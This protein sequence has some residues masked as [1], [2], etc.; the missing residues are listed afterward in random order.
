LPSDEPNSTSTSV[1]PGAHVVKDRPDVRDLPYRPTLGVLRG[2]QPVPIA[3]SS[4]ADF[5]RTQGNGSCTAHALAAVIDILRYDPELKGRGKIGRASPVSAAMLYKYGREIDSIDF[6]A[7]SSEGEGLW[8]LRSAIKAFYHNGVCEN[9]VW[10]AT[11]NHDPN[12]P[13]EIR[14]YRHARQTP[15]GSYYRVDPILND[16]HAAL[17]EV[18][19]IYAAAE[20]HGGWLQDNVNQNG[21]KII[22]DDSTALQ[23]TGKHAFAIVG[24]TEKGFLVLNSWGPEWGGYREGRSK[25]IK[26]VALWPYYDWAERILDGWVLRLGVKAPEAFKYSF[27]RQG[28]GDFLSGQIKEGSTPRFE[29][30]GHYA[31]LDDGD[32]V[33]GGTLPTSIE[34]VQDTCT[35]IS[36]KLARKPSAKAKADETYR[37]LLVWL[38]GGSEKM[39][40]IVAHIAATKQLWKQRGVYPFTL[41]WCSDLLD[42]ASAVLS[43]FAEGA[44]TNVGR[45]GLAFDTRLERDARGIGRAVWRDVINSAKKAAERDRSGDNK[46]AGAAQQVMEQFVQIDKDIEIHL[47][48][49]GA[50]AILA[51]ELIANNPDFAPRISSFT[52]IMPGFSIAQFQDFL[53]RSRAT[54][55]TRIIVPSSATQ[56]RLRYGEYN[57]SLL[58]LVQMTF[59]ETPPARLRD[60][61]PELQRAENAKLDAKDR[62]VGA[63]GAIEIQNKIAGVQ[64][65]EVEV[66][67]VNNRIT[68][69][70]DVTAGKEVISKIQETLLGA[71]KVVSPG[72]YGMLKGNPKGVPSA[73]K[74]NK[75]NGPDRVSKAD[76]RPVE[77]SVATSP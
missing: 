65:A 11:K 62:I 30:V 17:N 21:G 45:P 71:G 10:D 32:F 66:T 18:G 22:F 75:S 54:D 23:A 13:N 70:R 29:L 40:D 47:V 39:K 52:F 31:H 74:L 8:S 7:H 4:Y 37:K 67:G 48:A 33:A 36:R 59:V 19:V 16:Y 53:L 24:Y 9:A 73:R 72:D 34:S 44:L 14:I 50:G 3:I 64:V 63:M 15:L 61:N 35:Y 69:L 56:A 5:V 57:G 68:N 49:E 46:G 25:P 12:E 60:G 27:G 51:Y 58:D 77:E 76:T 2:V 43:K 38:P 28:L 55:R 41:I 1:F 26:G 20:I 42:Q 6:G